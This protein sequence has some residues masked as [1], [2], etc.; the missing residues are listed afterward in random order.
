MSAT[1][2]DYVPI[3]YPKWR[4]HHTH[5]PV[6]VADPVEEQ[7]LTPDEDGWVGMPGDVRKPVVPKHDE[8]PSAPI[9]GR[10]AKKDKANGK[11]D[12]VGA[13]EAAEV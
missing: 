10:R 4:Y 6:V 11:V 12:D 8:E 3:Q 2:P 1:P 7:A 13:E 9:L 5:K